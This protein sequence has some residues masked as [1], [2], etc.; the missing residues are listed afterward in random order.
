MKRTHHCGELRPGHIGQRVTLCGW[1]QKHR[2]LGGLIFIDLRDREGICQCVFDENSPL[3]G[4]AGQVRSEWCLSVTGTVRE[5]SAKNKNIPTGEIELDIT[6]LSVLSRAQT[7]PFEIEDEIKT[8]ELLRLE[9]RYLDLRRPALQKNLIVRH[10]AMQSVR[11][12]LDAQGFLEVETPILTASTPEGSRDYLVPSRLHAGSF[13]AL[14]Q[15]PQQ[16]KQLLMVS[17]IDRYFQLARC[18]RDE[19]LRADRQPEFTQIDLE[20]SFVEVDDILSICE[21]MIAALFLD[22]SGKEIPMPIPR[23]PWREAMERFGSDKPDLRFGLE[24]KNLTGL[25]RNC[26]FGVFD[27]AKS[28]GAINVSGGGKM[29]RREIDSLTAFVKGLGVKGL[30]WHKHDS[31]GFSK[32][33]SEDTLN[34]ICEE[35]NFSE[36]DLLLCIADESDRLV[37]T[38]L[39]ALRLECAS[40]LDLI[41]YDRLE[42]VWITEFPLFEYSEEEGRFVAQHHPFCSPMQEDIALLEPDENG[43][44]DISLARARAYDMVC[45]GYELSSGS[46]RIHQS[47][48]QEKMF[49]LLGL[50]EEEMEARF[51]HLL[52]AF[53]YGV[54]P[55]GGI[56]FGFDR[57]VMLLCKT[58]NIRD[59]VAFPK[60]QS[61]VCPMTGCPSPANAA[62][63]EELGLSLSKK[64]G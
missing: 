21:R 17:G 62:Q 63:L 61:A 20:M 55:H 45:N 6:E 1:V 58:S 13:Y 28:V 44:L 53:S 33:L 36:G 29:S 4:Q 49:S 50:S 32:F 12:F 40:R 64:D 26:G 59:V 57:L 2:D 60:T 23:M 16:Y 3:R 54:P 18:L 39:G 52:K 56:G 10:K 31:S 5:R 15:S 8:S 27:G 48:V 35:T 34:K 7:T 51:G 42:F 9:Y 47:D 22:V 38:S 46:I 25:T 37:K 43:V 14:P 11:R 19:D 30:A 24:L 41:D